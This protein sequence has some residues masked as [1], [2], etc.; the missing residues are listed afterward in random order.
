[1]KN[2]FAIIMVL[3]FG[4]T[5]ASA[6]N[7]ENRD[8]VVKCAQEG[9]DVCQ[10][11]LG[12]WIFEGSHGYQQDYEKAVAWWMQAAKKNNDEAVAN[13]GFCYMYGMGV[14]ADSTTAS[15]LFE[16]ALKLGNKQ[17]ETIH[18]SLAATGVV[19]SNMLLA[20]C[21]KLGY[22]VK[23]NASKALQYY[24][25]AAELDNVEAMREAAI[26]MRSSK[27][28]TAALATFDKAMQ[29][30]DVA[31]TYYY[32][33]MLCE[34]RGA[35]RNVKAGVETIRK[36]ADKG[37][38]AAQ[39]E[40]AEAYANGSGVDSNAAEAFRW[41]SAAARSGNRAAWWQKAECYRNGIGTYID[42]EEAMECYAKAA[43]LGYQNKLGALLS[44]ESTEWKDTPFMHYLRGMRQLLVNPN[45]NEAIKEFSALPK[46]M[47]VRKTME[48]VCMSHHLYNKRNIAKAAKQLQ[49]L[50]SNNHRAAFE[51]AM[52]LLKGEG[53]DKDVAKAEKMLTAL[54]AEGYAPAVCWLAD[55]YYDGTL[56]KKD[57]SKA[58]L[59]YLQLEKSQRLTDLGAGRLI[60]AYKNGDGVKADAQRVEQLKKYRVYDV[61]KLLAMIKM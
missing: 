48:A 11:L 24:K 14:A 8:D 1:M 27:D 35:A 33:K 53:I 51:Y 52:L 18:D 49:A 58:L 4:A 34:G 31:S 3:V 47:N 15:R 43:D 55:A 36:A 28:D 7:T 42:F 9:N 38:A 50:S 54:A 2:L 21:Y 6:Q 56:L 37:Y 45:P 29:K 40:L 17:V 60:D 22:G 13:L 25:K 44:G 39:Y 46:Q 20:K 57:R 41:Y 5:L 32:G 59:L 19:F 16:K 26:M 61:N 23:A 30:G 12:K 10:T